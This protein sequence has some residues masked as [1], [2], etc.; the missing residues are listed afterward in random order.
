VRSHLPFPA[1]LEAQALDVSA[2]V[3]QDP[4]AG[5]EVLRRLL[6]DGRIVLQPQPDGV[7][8]EKTAILPLVLLAE[9]DRR[10]PG[11]AVA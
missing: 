7:Y 3:A 6:Q 2:R 4:L 1:Q 9:R 5:R 10:N 8:V 11:P